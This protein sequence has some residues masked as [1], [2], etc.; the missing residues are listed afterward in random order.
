MALEAAIDMAERRSY[1]FGVDM[2][3]DWAPLVG[4]IREDLDR[5]R[6]VGAIA[7]RFHHTLVKWICRVADRLQIG[8]VVLSGGVFQNAFL[9]ERTV[10]ALTARRHDVYLHRRIPTNDGGLS[11]GQLVIARGLVCA[12]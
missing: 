2:V 11:F 5:R 10:A 8:P 12:R 1:P 4:A 6:P 7:A 3:G 9:V